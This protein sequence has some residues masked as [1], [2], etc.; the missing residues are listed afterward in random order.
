M[1]RSEWQFGIKMYRKHKDL[2]QFQS[3]ISPEN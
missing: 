1:V 3:Q 2:N